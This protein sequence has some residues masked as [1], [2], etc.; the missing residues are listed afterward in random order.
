MRTGI[1]TAAYDFD[2]ARVLVLGGVKIPGVWGLRGPADG[3]VL[4]RAL[5]DAVLGAAGL[6][7][8]ADHARDGEDDEPSAARLADCMVKLAARDLAVAHVD[9][10]LLTDRAEVRAARPAMA[11]RLANLLGVGEARVNL[12]TAAAESG[13]RGTDGIGALVVAGLV[14]ATA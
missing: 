9:A 4:I 8:L 6:G 2:P 5:A 1:A 10:S 12:K 11:A 14:E 7:D 3:D 13:A